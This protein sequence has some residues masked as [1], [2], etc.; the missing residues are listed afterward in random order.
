[1]ALVAPPPPEMP[2]GGMPPP[3][4]MPSDPTMAA[5]P[6]MPSSAP[7]EPIAGTGGAGSYDDFIDLYGLAKS[8]QQQFYQR[9]SHN[10]LHYLSWQPVRTHSSL[11]NSYTL[12]N[13]LQFDGFINISS[14]LVI[15]DQ[16]MGVA[17]SS[18]AFKISCNCEA[19]SIPTIIRSI[20]G[21]EL[22]KLMHCVNASNS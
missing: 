4:E 19:V 3:P 9:R 14:L 8:H 15:C 12:H 17:Q 20:L 7:P 6:A 18:F 16:S 21:N 5:P 10:R 22:T 13:L 11:N 2:G 1:M